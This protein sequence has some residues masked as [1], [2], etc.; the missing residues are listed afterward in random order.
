MRFV[1]RER[2]PHRIKEDSQVSIPLSTMTC[3]TTLSAVSRP[4]M[5]IAAAAHS[6]S[7]SSVGWGAWSVATQSMVP[8]ASPTRS[9]CTSSAVRKGGLTL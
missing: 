7:L 1:D 4:S 8:S 5:P 2:F 9:A 6:H 3:W